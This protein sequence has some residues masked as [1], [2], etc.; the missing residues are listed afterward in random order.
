[1]KDTAARAPRFYVDAAL[2]AGGT[3]VL[4]EGAAH[5]AVHVLRVSDHGDAGP[6]RRAFYN[7]K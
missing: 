5:H 4:A 6:R 7:K 3:C 2:R 1:M